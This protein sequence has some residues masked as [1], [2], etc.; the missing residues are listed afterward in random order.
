MCFRD[1]IDLAREQGARVFELRAVASLVRLEPQPA[2][3][4]VREQL[5]ACS[6]WFT[7][8]LDLA[9]QRE[10]RALLSALSAP[11]SPA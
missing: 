3:A 10:V 7:E 11:L 5:A 6:A 9:D 4:A 1:A 8:G 2:S